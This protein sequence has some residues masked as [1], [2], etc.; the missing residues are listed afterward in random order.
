MG[1]GVQ[2]EE[3][4]HADAGRHDQPPYPQ[5]HGIQRLAVLDQGQAHR[6]DTARQ[7][8]AGEDVGRPVRAEIDPRHGDRQRRQAAQQDPGQAHA[9]RLAPPGEDGEGE[10]EGE[11]RGAVATGH[12]VGGQRVGQHFRA[13]AG[14]EPFQ[15]GVADGGATEGGG[16]E[17]GRAPLPGQQQQGDQDGGDDELGAEVPEA[18]DQHHGAVEVAAAVFLDQRHQ[19]LVELGQVGPADEHRHQHRQADRRD[20][21]GAAGLG[22]QRAVDAEADQ[23]RQARGDHTGLRPETFRQ[24]QAH[25]RT[26]GP[27]G[28]Q[29]G[30]RPA[31]GGNQA[32]R[33]K[34]RQRHVEHPRDHRQHRSQR[35]DESADQQAGDAVAMEIGF[36]AAYPFRVMAQ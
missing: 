6:T 20:Q 31:S 27:A 11:R 15:A 33:D 30:Q 18:G 28:Q 16:G 7:Q 32:D 8:A 23:Y 13:G 22:A 36:R 12:A 2:G 14:E 4:Q 9:R 1:Q 29:V 21:A 25:G 3:R 17:E 26:G 34:A 5:A 35:A 10:E 24:R 19:A